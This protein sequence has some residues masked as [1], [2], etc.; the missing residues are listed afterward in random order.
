MKF[1]TIYKKIL[2]QSKL[3]NKVYDEFEKACKYFHF[4]TQTDANI[5]Q[6]INGNSTGFK[7]QIKNTFD[8]IVINLEYQNITIKNEI[9]YINISSFTYLELCKKIRIFLNSLT[10][11]FL[12]QKIDNKIDIDKFLSVMI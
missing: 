11:K 1:N 4:L 8:T 6:W 12:L 5:F 3:A 2:F 9:L 7:F 10:K